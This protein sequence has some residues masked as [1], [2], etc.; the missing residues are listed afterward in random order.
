MLSSQANSYSYLF[1]G[2]I[3]GEI[4]EHPLIGNYLRENE[5][6]LRE[7]DIKDIDCLTLNSLKSAKT[8]SE[9][10]VKIINDRFEQNGKKTILFAHSKA[11]LEVMIAL[12]ENTEIFEMKVQHVV[13]VQPPFAG[14]ALLDNFAIRPFM[15]I[16]PG[17]ECLKKD[18]Y[19]EYFEKKVNS[20]LE[21]YINNK[22]L[23]IKGHHPRPQEVSWI[24]RTPHYLMKKLGLENDGLVALNEQKLP[25]HN[26]K[27]MT[28]EID[29][30]DLFTSE[31]LSGKKTEFRRKMMIE[32]INSLLSETEE[33]YNKSPDEFR[34][35]QSYQ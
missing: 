19:L 9:T 24:I 6:I 3:L 26:Y 20:D 5:K 1:L 34:S 15:K 4:L 31:R 2:G 14:S 7:L 21:K 28:L 13:C 16:W 18:Y 30:S 27:E 35:Y 10:L 32:L 17:L 33:F 12:I 29:H 22:L 11:C 25:W 23:V 8:N